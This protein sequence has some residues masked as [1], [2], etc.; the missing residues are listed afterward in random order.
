MRE[1]LFFTTSKEIAHRLTEAFDFV[2]P[3]A[4]AMWNLRWQVDGFL[5]AIP[6]ATD[7]TL[8]NRFISGSGIRSASLKRSCVQLS[9][10]SQKEQFAKFLLI[11]F[12]ALYEA[13]ID[14]VFDELGQNN[15]LSKQ[16]QFPTNG[17]NGVGSVLAMLHANISPE[18]QASIY[19]VL[20]TNRK[21]SFAQL[22]ELLVC[23]RY[24]KECRNAI[25][26]YGGVATAKSVNAYSAYSLLNASSLGVSE[27]PEHHAISG[28]GSIV[29]LSLRGVVGFGEVVLKLI[30]TLDAEISKASIAENVLVERWVTVIGKGRSLPADPMLKEG[31]ILRL[32]RKLD[33][34]A[35]NSPAS[36]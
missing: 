8:S 19:P 10:D 29:K 15:G 21:Y 30:S 26:H 6:D 13:W 17:A 31:A 24:F 34:P 18:L 7:A 1:K 33:L 28:Q 9:W 4:A 5:R 22:N 23:Y 11:E 32:I 12:C 25:V 36:L 35:P 16:L 3:T 27:V 2:W 20:Q 14:G